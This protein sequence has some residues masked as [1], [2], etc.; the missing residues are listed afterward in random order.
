MASQFRMKGLLKRGPKL[1][2]S[3][4]WLVNSSSHR[5]PLGVSGEKQ[6]LM[7]RPTLCSHFYWQGNPPKSCTLQHQICFQ[8]SYSQPIS[9]QFFA[10]GKP[11]CQLAVNRLWR[12]RGAKLII[13]EI[14]TGILCSKRRNCN[15]C[16]L[17]EMAIWS[18]GSCQDR[19]GTEDANT[20][21][22]EGTYP[23]GSPPPINFRGI[24]RDYYP[25]RLFTQLSSRDHQY[26]HHTL[27]T[28]PIIAMLTGFSPH[29][30]RLSSLPSLQGKL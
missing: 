21:K 14:E 26:K 7:N 20:K 5:Y 2:W 1:S 27:A 17:L 22:P 24:P 15:C 12:T 23:P 29:A 9:L 18:N 25:L 3:V 19:S 30:S 13:H 4:R 10:A 8:L 16:Q 6:T 28:S 11:F